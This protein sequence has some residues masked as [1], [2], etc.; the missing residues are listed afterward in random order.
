MNTTFHNQ[1]KLVC[2]HYFSVPLMLC[3]CLIK[4]QCSVTHRCGQDD[5][6]ILDLKE[7][8]DLCIARQLLTTQSQRTKL[9]IPALKALTAECFDRGHWQDH[10]T[11]I[12]ILIIPDICK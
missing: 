3:V 6:G 7:V 9:L 12:Y 5:V 2:H 10:K 11:I 8:I 4:M 1:L